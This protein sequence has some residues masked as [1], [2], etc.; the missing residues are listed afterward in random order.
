MKFLFLL[1]FLY[2]VVSPAVTSPAAASEAATSPQV[3][4]S[5]SFSGDPPKPKIFWLTKKYKP[6]V[7]KILGHKYPALRLRYWGKQARTVWILEETGKEKPITTGIVIN[8]DRIEKIK[9]LI[10]R[11]SRGFE[12]KYDFFTNQFVNL[13]LTK[14]NE[15]SDHVD[16]ISGASLSVSAIKRLAKLALYF[17]QNTKFSSKK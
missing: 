6:D 17:H 10:Y 15:L 12:V 14:G 13:G 2:S 9:I 1:V 16:G 8:N 3:F 11:E 4:V 5:D 7:K